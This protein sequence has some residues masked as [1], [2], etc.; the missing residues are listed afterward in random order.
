MI[1]LLN[2]CVLLPLLLWAL[3]LPKLAVVLLEFNPNIQTVVICTGTEMVTLT[4]GPDGEPL[5]IG[6]GEEAPCVTTEDDFLAVWTDPKWVTLA[7]DYIF[8]FVITANRSERLN[9]ELLSR[10]SQAPPLA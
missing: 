8:A 2:A 9:P 4:V 1:R 10:D 3:L 6:D 5:Q 7:R